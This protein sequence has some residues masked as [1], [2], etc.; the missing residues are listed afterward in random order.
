[1]DNA[2]KHRRYE[3]A[4]LQIFGQAQMGGVQEEGS[5][6]ENTAD[7]GGPGRSTEYFHGCGHR[8]FVW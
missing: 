2:N 1:M 8:Y 6:S 4:D 3:Q 7:E 5:S